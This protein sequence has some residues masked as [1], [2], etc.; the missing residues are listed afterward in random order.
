[1][2]ANVSTMSSAGQKCNH[3]RARNKPKLM[4]LNFFVLIAKKFWR[5]RKYTT[6]FRFGP[7]PALLIA[8]VELN[9][10]VASSGYPIIHYL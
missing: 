7:Y 5:L 10:K 1:M 8:N 2:Y 6:A 9:L 4:F 3:F